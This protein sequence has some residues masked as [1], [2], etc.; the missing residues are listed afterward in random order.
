[1]SLDHFM[2]FASGVF[3]SAGVAILYALAKGKPRG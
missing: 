3:V 2:Y 1:M